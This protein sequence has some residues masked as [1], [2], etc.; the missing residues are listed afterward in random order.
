[1]EKYEHLKVKFK[2]SLT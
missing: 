2:V 1:M